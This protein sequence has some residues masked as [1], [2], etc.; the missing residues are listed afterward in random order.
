[1][2]DVAVGLLPPPRLQCSFSRSALISYDGVRRLSFRTASPSQATSLFRRFPLLALERRCCAVQE[3]LR[4]ARRQLGA[5]FLADQILSSNCSKL[6]SCVSFRS[7]SVVRS[8]H[9]CQVNSMYA[10]PSFFVEIFECC[11]ARFLIE[12]LS[13]HEWFVSGS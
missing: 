11:G 13:V 7:I 2:D 10:R 1:M 3:F 6:Y 9:P 8:L 4:Q 5:F 12:V